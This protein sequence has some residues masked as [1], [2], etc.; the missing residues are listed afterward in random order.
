MKKGSIEQISMFVLILI[1]AVIIILVFF[2]G[3]GLLTKSK[4]QATDKIKDVVNTTTSSKTKISFEDYYGRVIYL[5][6][7][8]EYAKKVL[9]D[10]VLDCLD[11]CIT[12][13]ESM[14][15]YYFDASYIAGFSFEDIKK[16]INVVK[17][18]S[19]DDFNID[20]DFES[21][22]LTLIGSKNLAYV[23]ESGTGIL[24]IA[25]PKLE[26]CCS[27]KKVYLSKV[28]ECMSKVLRR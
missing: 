15:C 26:M 19:F 13:D 25:Y 1:I 8:E 5:S 3:S 16:L 6:S 21:L 18:E 23:D 24:D 28:N 12:H 4:E 11:L 9:A 2:S 27:P 17:A 7:N 20:D 22:N 14:F 10:S